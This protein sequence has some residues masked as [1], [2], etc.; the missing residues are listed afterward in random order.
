MCVVSMVG[1][2]YND[3]WK[4]YF[5]PQNKIWPKWPD[6]NKTYPAPSVSRIEFN[7]LKK[8]VEEMI[9]LM[10]RAKKYDADNNEP[11]CEIEDKIGFIRKVAKLVSVDL[12]KELGTKPSKPSAK[13]K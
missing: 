13:R 5:P 6:D 11:D 1:D 4:P 12:D 8:Q 9:A 2:H 3:K 10:K 7:E